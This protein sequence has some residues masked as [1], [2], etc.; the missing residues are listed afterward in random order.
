M[1]LPEAQGEAGAAAAD[2]PAP[3]MHHQDP[4]TLL[5]ALHDVAA[6]RPRGA[7]E[8][9]A[10]LADSR[11]QHFPAHDI[12]DP[13][14]AHRGFIAQRDG[15]PMIGRYG[16]QRPVASLL[17]GCDLRREVVALREEGAI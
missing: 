15:E 9:E 3:S 14:V 1:P 8:G 17:R 16:P 6:C 4:R 11:T 12:H 2:E 7:I 10:A 13:Q 5:T